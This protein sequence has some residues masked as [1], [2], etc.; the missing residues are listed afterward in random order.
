[1]NTI[2][3]FVLNSPQAK[4]HSVED[5]SI[6]SSAFWLKAQKTALMPISICLPYVSG[7][8]RGQQ[9]PS[10]VARHLNELQERS[11]TSPINN[12]IEHSTVR[13]FLSLHSKY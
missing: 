2:V 10:G 9:A 1:M 6:N 8:T 4:C 12:E 7:V 5:S 3:P 13:L 11:V